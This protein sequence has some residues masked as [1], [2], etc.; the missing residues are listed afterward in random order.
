MQLVG[1][2]PFIISVWNFFAPPSEDQKEIR[3]KVTF[4]QNR[5]YFEGNLDLKAENSP[6][7]NQYLIKPGISLAFPMYFGDETLFIELDPT[8]GTPDKPFQL[9]AGTTAE[10]FPNAILGVPVAGSYCDKRT[11]PKGD[12]YYVGGSWAIDPIAKA[13]WQLTI[14]KFG[15]D[16]QSDDVTVGPGTPG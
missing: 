8:G 2:Y 16:P 12:T 14:R 9:S 10:N 4:T 15:P 1:N 5:C 7:V 13:G 11:T 6:T 3:F